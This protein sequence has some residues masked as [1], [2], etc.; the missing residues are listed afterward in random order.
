M[1]CTETCDSRDQA[2]KTGHPILS[3]GAKQSPDERNA[4]I[5][6]LHRIAIAFESRPWYRGWTGLLNQLG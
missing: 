1:L 4:R 2:L 3:F 5:S 6:E